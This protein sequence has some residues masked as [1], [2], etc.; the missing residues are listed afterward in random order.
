VN[1]NVIKSKKNIKSFLNCFLDVSK[2]GKSNSIFPISS[3]AKLFIIFPLG[4]MKA[5]NP[6]LADLIVKVSTS[7]DRKIA[8]EKC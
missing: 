6:L 5:L 2:I 3:G 8:L 4:L 1:T 7:I